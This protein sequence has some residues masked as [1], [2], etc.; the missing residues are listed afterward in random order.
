MWPI[1]VEFGS[2]NSEIRRG[3]RKK[4]EGRRIP[5]KT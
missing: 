3:K 1:L 2:A 5:G 4:K